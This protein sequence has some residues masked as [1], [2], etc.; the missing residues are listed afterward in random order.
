MWKENL[1]NMYQKINHEP[2]TVALYSD[3]S[4]LTHVS[5]KPDPNAYAVDAFSLVWKQFKF[6]CFPPFSC[7]KSVSKK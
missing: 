6:Y 7:I 5:Y 1:P 2:P 4:N 3:A